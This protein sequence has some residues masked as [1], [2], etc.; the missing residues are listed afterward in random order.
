[1][2]PELCE[3]A[4]WLAALRKDWFEFLLEHTPEMLFRIDGSYLDS[5]QKKK[6]AAQVLAQA[7]AEDARAFSEVRRLTPAFAF[8]GLA[9]LLKLTFADTEAHPMSRRLALQ[10]VEECRLIE[11]DEDLWELFEKPGHED[12]RRWIGGALYDVLRG[13]HTQTSLD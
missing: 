10:I 9:E 6:L 12:L 8:P 5:P 2:P 7:Q 1:M 11:L 13:R 4:A 3:T